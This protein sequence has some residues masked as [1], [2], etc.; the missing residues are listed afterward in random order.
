MRR[1][2]AR[3]AT[4][5]GRPAGLGTESNRR[6]RDLDKFVER[7]WRRAAGLNRREECPRARF[8]TLVLLPQVHAGEAGPAEAFQFLEVVQLQ[9]ASLR[10]DLDPLLRERLRAVREVVDRTD[11]SVRK[12]QMDRRRVRHRALQ[13]EPLAGN[14][15]TAGQESQQVDEE[16]RRAND[17]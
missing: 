10:E 14:D 12:S 15:R 6:P 3:Y 5:P 16:A 7:D 11:G 1:T 4:R 2:R 9:D 13:C 17:G 8:L